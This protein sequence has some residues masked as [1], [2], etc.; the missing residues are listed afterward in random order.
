MIVC[1][2]NN[3]QKNQKCFCLNCITFSA[4][5]TPAAFLPVL[6][7]LTQLSA[8]V[9]GVQIIMNTRHRF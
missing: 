4:N 1:G 6:G 9:H 5:E 3:Y 2:E 7:F 8:D